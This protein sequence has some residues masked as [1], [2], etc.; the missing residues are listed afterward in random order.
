MGGRKSKPV[1]FEDLLRSTELEY[2]KIY[3][4]YEQL[5]KE[6]KSGYLTKDDIKRMYNRKYFNGNADEFAEHVFRCYDTDKNGKVD[7]RE[8][9]CGLSPSIRGTKRQKLNFAFSVVDIDGDGYITRDEM[10]TVVKV[11]LNKMSVVLS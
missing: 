8:F 10:I 7:F 11:G 4:L 2:T 1:S 6:H 5:L 3:E 9:M